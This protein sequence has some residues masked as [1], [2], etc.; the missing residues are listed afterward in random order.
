[1]AFVEDSLLKFF[2]IVAVQAINTESENVGCSRGCEGILLSPV[3][4]A[5]TVGRSYGEEADGGA[6]RVDQRIR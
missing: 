2:F 3:C 4:G 5:Y 6:A 1:M